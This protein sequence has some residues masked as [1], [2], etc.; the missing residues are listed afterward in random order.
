VATIS[1]PGALSFL[2]RYK[3]SSPGQ[4]EDFKQVMRDIESLS[5]AFMP[6]NI[7]P[8]LRACPGACR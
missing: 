2:M 6:L 5:I 1:T 4:I 3:A 7:S 8:V